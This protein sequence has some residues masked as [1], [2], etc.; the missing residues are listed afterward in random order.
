MKCLKLLISAYSCRPGMGSEPG[1]GWNVVKQL[2]Q[3]NQVWVLTR[4]DNRP[5]IETELSQN[6]IAELQFIYYN[7]PWWFRWL[8]SGQQ[9]HYY[10]WQIGIYFLAKQFHAQIQFDVAHHQ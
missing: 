1:V 5:L 3:H 7:L 10:L 9:L 6:P 8:K 2:A 4:N